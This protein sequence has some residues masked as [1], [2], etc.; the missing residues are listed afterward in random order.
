MAKRYTFEPVPDTDF[1]TWIQK[2]DD[3]VNAVVGLSVHD[4]RD[5]PFRA[6]FNADMDPAEAA[7]ETLADAGWS[8]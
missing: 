5:Q 3:E 8:E 6:W 7:E 1:T 4:L 2:V